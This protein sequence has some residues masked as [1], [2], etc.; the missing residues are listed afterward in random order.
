MGRQRKGRDISGILVID[1]PAGLTSNGVL[2]RVK[3]LYGAAKA[4]HTGALDPIATGVLPICLGEATKFSQ[5]LLDSDKRYITRVQLGESRTTGD[6]EGEVI[7]QLPIPP[8]SAEIIEAALQPLRGEIT[9]IPPIYSALKHEGKKL[10]ELARAGIEYDIRKK[11]RQVTIH[12]LELTGFGEDWI[13][14]D[15]TCSKGTYI[16][17]LAEDVAKALNTLGFV[18]MLRRLG[19]GPYVPEMMLTLEQLEELVGAEGDFSQLDERLLPSYTAL[20]S[21]PI[22]YISEDQAK[23][24][25]FG[26]RIIVNKGGELPLAQVQLR[27]ANTPEDILIGIAEHSIAGEVLPQRLLKVAGLSP[28][29]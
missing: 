27:V 3:R 25:L 10:Y 16:R 22:L 20:E 18:A 9:Q 8:L 19:A 12:N 13:E 29:T 14:L 26:R 15:V 23:E 28:V 5:R 21:V 2:Q 24:L 17:S 11:A 6:I 1:K 7:E 4:G